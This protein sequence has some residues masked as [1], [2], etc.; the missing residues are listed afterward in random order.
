LQWGPWKKLSLNKANKSFLHY[1]T[2]SRFLQQDPS[3]SPYLSARSFWPSQ[4]R[5]RRELAGGG[6]K[7]ARR[8]RWRG[9]VPWR[10][11]GALRSGHGLAGGG[12]WPPGPVRQRRPRQRSRWRGLWW[13]LGPG[14][15]ALG[16]S[17]VTVRA[18]GLAARAEE[19][20]KLENDSGGELSP[21]A[22]ADAAASSS[23][24][25]AAVRQR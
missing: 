5:G 18:Q 14:K 16:V 25:G 9:G 2:E 24:G 20:R 23:G 3:L 17:H 11:P 21:H 10:C 15:Q 19:A 4:S 12:S 6:R 22:M 7:R 13:R 1:S 8:R